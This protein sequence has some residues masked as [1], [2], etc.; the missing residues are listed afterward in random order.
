VAISLKSAR[1]SLV[2]CSLLLVAV[3]LIIALGVIPSVTVDTSPHA[4]P[5]R[6]VPAFWVSVALHL[7]AA[8][9][10]LEVGITTRGRTVPL[11]VMQMVVCLL[12]LLLGYGLTD[13]AAACLGHGP[14]MHRT[15]ILL[16]ASAAATCISALIGISV[17]YL[18]PKKP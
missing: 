16:F 2:V 10:F 12:V 9:F 8:A 5:E 17:A 3:A 6:A 13:A 18:I 15:A 4:T 14:Q 7:L 11:M 1:V